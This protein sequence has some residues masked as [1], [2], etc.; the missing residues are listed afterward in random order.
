MTTNHLRFL[1]YDNLE[2]QRY[3][4][5]ISYMSF[6]SKGRKEKQNYH[7]LRVQLKLNFFRYYLCVL[8]LK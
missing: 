8:L 1:F 2:M 6:I 7:Q 5:H 4:S 3:I